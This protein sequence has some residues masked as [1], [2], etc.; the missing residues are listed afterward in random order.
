MTKAVLVI[1]ALVGGLIFNAVAQSQ[2]RDW[3][4]ERV[5]RNAPQQECVTDEGQGRTNPC[6]AGAGGGN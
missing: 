6:D 2:P 3:E 5:Y 1:S 4:Q